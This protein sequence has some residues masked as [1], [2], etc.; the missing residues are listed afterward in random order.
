ML[1]LAIDQHSKQLTVNLRNEEGT[2]VERRQV[3]TD[4]EAVE[5]YFRELAERSAAEGGYVAL[6]E[7]CG[8]NDWLLDRLPTWGCRKILLVQ[9]EQ[10]ARRKTDRRDANQLGELLWVNRRRLLSGQRVQGLRQVCL[11]TAVEREDRRLTALRRELGARR[12]RILN[13]L[14]HLLLRHNLRQAMPTRGL[15]TVAARRWLTHLALSGWTAWKWLNCWRI[16]SCAK[17]I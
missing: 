9:P 17:R 2:V 5:G 12:T 8:F 14:Q 13:R 4:W 7:V 1:Y 16:G 6:V 3:S 15:Q 11:P 10:R